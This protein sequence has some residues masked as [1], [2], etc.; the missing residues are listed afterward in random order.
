[1]TARRD[2]RG[3]WFQPPK[4]IRRLRKDER[5]VTAIEFGMLAM[6]FFILLLGIIETSLM[7]FAGQVLESATDEVGRLVRT[8]QLDNTM[9]AE[10]LRTEICDRSEILFACKDILIDMQVVATYKDLGDSPEPDEGE[11]APSDF[12]FTAAGPRQIVMLTV[13]TEWP[14]FTNYFQKWLSD[15]N[16]GNAVL[17]AVTVFKTE[18]Y[19]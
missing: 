18:P 5:G 11:L 12:G 8:G 2:R 6:P 13:V 4:I 17:T 16:N 15:L 9:T 19:S 3:G 10:E 14:V 1:M 7:F